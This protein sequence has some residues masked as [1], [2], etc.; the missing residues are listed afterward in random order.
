MVGL[1]ESLTLIVSITTV[2]ESNETV[3][4]IPTKPMVGRW[5]AGGE[6]TFHIHQLNKKM[7]IKTTNKTS[8]DKRHQ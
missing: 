8:S 1:T 5:L 2:S 3:H 4:N 6:R 7:K